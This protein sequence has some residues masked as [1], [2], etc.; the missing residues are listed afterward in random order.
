M[1]IDFQE[2]YLFFGFSAARYKQNA[3]LSSSNKKGRSERL[4]RDFRGDMI[5]QNL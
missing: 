5:E 4:T 3:G 2:P 1:I